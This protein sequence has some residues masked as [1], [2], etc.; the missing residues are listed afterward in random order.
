MTVRQAKQAAVRD[1]VLAEKVARDFLSLDA[2]LD[3]ARKM[4][5]DNP[6]ALYRLG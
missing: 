4:F 3:L 6:M 1:R 5:R 2:A